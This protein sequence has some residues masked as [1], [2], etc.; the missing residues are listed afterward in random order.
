MLQGLRHDTSDIDPTLRA[1]LSSVGGA[2]L[3]RWMLPVIATSISTATMDW[4]EDA[5]ESWARFLVGDHLVAFVFM[6]APLAILLDDICEP[7]A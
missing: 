6:K 5:G 7:L 3:S 4:D 1:A 2:E